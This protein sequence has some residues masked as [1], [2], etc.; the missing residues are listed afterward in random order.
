MISDLLEEALARAGS[1]K[2][3]ANILDL[4]PSEIC[5]IR[6]GEAGMR[7]SKMSKLIEYSGFV[8][9][10]A[11]HEKKLREALKTVSQLWAD[12]DK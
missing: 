6:S 8:L 5:R 10:P 2:E 3:L 1:G 12:A 11:D 9:V 4:S 7:L